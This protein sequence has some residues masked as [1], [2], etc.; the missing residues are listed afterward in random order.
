MPIRFG[1]LFERF[2]AIPFRQRLYSVEELAGLYESVGMRLA[3]TFS[4][5]G[6]P[7]VPKP[8]QYEIFVEGR[9]G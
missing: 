2:E 3:N 7:R 5:G 9:K 4:G 1:E 6:K 8:N